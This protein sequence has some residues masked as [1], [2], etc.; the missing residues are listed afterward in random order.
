MNMPDILLKLIGYVLYFESFVAIALSVVDPMFEKKHLCMKYIFLQFK[1]YC[2]VH[3]F[4]YSQPKMRKNGS[5]KMVTIS[6]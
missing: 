3:K 6:A 4:D 1:L 2:K 5:N